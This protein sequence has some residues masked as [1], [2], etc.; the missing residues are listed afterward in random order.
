MQ[1]SARCAIVNQQ[2]LALLQ[3]KPPSVVVIVNHWTSYKTVPTYGTVEQ[4][5]TSLRMTLQVLD[6]LAIPVIIQYQ[7]P[8]CEFQNRLV[9]VRLFEGRIVSGSKCLTKSRD[10]EMRLAIGEQ[11]SK[12]AEDCESAPCEMADLSPLLC[13]AICLPFR[14]SVNIFADASHISPSASRLTASFYQ[15]KIRKVL[16]AKQRLP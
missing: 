15:D 9:G 12:L 3:S 4:Q 6:A 16:L 10:N 2:R 14:D 11:V 5:V 8:I 1:T 7:I 13:D